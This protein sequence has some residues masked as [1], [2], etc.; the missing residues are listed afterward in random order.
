MTIPADWTPD[1]AQP[2]VESALAHIAALPPKKPKGAK[3]AP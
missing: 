2:W 1:D 3:K